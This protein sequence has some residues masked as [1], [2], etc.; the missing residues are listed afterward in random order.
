MFN[1]R[2]HGTVDKPVPIEP[3]RRAAKAIPRS[4]LI[5]YDGTSHGLLVTERERVT[6]DLLQFLSA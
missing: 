5:E 2:M 1:R 3:G 4:K 6:R